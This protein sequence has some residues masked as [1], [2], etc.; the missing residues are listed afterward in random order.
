VTS[1]LRI[2]SAA[3]TTRGFDTEAFEEVAEVIADRLQKPADA[4]VELR[5]RERVKALCD[6]SPLYGP[7]KVAQMV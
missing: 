4:V 6:R 3:L 5:C 1:G 2:G 7:S